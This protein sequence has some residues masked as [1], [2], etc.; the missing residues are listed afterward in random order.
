[1]NERER[2]GIPESLIHE[3]ITP[4]ISAKTVEPVGEKRKTLHLTYHQGPN[5]CEVQLEGTGGICTMLRTTPAQPGKVIL[6]T[7]G[8]GSL[9]KCMNQSKGR[10]PEHQCK[11][12]GRTHTACACTVASYVQIRLSEYASSKSS[13][14]P[15]L[16]TAK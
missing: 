16:S 8:L 4:W 14:L 9:L 2:S 1:M 3:S 13:F 6:V 5:K 12:L 7:C 10:V 11:L 15:P